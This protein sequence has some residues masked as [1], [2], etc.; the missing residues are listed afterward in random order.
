MSE[1]NVVS[2]DERRPTVVIPDDDGNQRVLPLSLFEDILEGKKE[3]TDIE[4]WEG[5]IRPI[6]HDA[7]GLWMMFQEEDNNNETIH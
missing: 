2:L 3:F 1:D 5:L 6:L 7:Y 4:G